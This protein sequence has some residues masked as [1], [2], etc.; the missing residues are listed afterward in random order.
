MEFRP[1]PQT[2]PDAELPT[3]VSTLQSHSQHIPQQGGADENVAE[4]GSSSLEV[5]LSN[6]FKQYGSNLTP[7]DGY[8]QEAQFASGEDVIVYDDIYPKRVPGSSLK[9]S[10]SPINSNSLSSA[11][12]DLAR[13]KARQRLR[14]YRRLKARQRARRRKDLQV[15][16]R[17]K[18]ALCPFARAHDGLA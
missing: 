5:H 12:E 11:E 18:S 7:P 9:N 3:P 15:R 1:S 10:F 2:T 14:E 6:P 16:R 8:N 4:G 17:R 13:A